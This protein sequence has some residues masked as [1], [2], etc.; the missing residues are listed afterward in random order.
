MSAAMAS[1]AFKVKGT[2]RTCVIF[3][4]AA[5]VIVQPKRK[6]ASLHF[7]GNSHHLPSS[8]RSSQFAT[9]FT[10]RKMWSRGG[11]PTPAA[12]EVLF[13]V[14]VQILDELLDRGNRGSVR[15][16]LFASFHL[17]SSLT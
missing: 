13:L 15:D 5:G 10:E 4:G 8:I 7:G 1:A 9:F 3:D 12:V 11:L 14:V 6:F 2:A 16:S 17:P